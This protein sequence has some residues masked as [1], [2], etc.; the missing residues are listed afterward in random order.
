MLI[1][2]VIIRLKTP[3]LS[4][5][6]EPPVPT[7]S[8]PFPSSS[9][10]NQTLR[11]GCR[12][13]PAMSQR[14]LRKEHVPSVHEGLASCFGQARKRR[15]AECCRTKTRW[16]PHMAF[17][18]QRAGLGYVQARPRRLFLMYLP[19]LG[20]VLKGIQKEPPSFRTPNQHF[21]GFPY[22]ETNPNEPQNDRMSTF[23]LACISSCL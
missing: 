3:A 18:G 11:S 17:S 12:K 16:V 14:K 2:Q 15:L 9:R 8:M 6:H 1:F 22:L 5:Y 10:A 13:N 23:A 7:T 4:T 21:E 19:L 20:L